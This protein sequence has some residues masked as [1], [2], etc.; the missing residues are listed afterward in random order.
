MAHSSLFALNIHCHL[1]K[2]FAVKREDYAT[3]FNFIF[4]AACSVQ[5]ASNLRCSYF[6]N[7]DV[8][9]IVVIV[10]VV[11]CRQLCVWFYIRM[12]LLNVLDVTVKTACRAGEK[13]I[14]K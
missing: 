1:V 6:T 2:Q 5:S 14:T 8:I 11:R 4:R 13:E 7:G 12:S 10:V 3:F 9:M